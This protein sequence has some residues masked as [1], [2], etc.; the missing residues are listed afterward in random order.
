MT[1]AARADH[2]V[3]CR[4]ARR[5]VQHA[6]QRVAADQV[7]LRDAPRQ[8]RI[9]IARTLGLVVGRDGDGA[10]IDDSLMLRV[11]QHIIAGQ[12]VVAVGQGVTHVGVTVAGVGA[13]ERCRGSHTQRFAFDQVG[14]RSR[15]CL[16]GRAAV[17]D[18]ASNRG[19]LDTEHATRNGGARIGGV[20]HIV[21]GVAASQA[22]GDRLAL[23][24]VLVGEAARD[25]QR[26]ARDDAGNGIRAGNRCHGVAVVDLVQRAER[27]V[28]LARRDRCRGR[29]VGADRVVAGVS[30]RQRTADIHQL[31]DGSIL[32]R[33][34]ARR[35]QRNG[36]ALDHAVERARRIGGSGAVIGLAGGRDG[37]RQGLGRDVGQRRGVG[38]QLVVA[39]VGAGQDT[40]HRH[41][42]AIAHV[43]VAEQARGIDG[44][45]VALHHAVQRAGGG[46]IARAV[47]HLAGGRQRTAGL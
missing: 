45:V 47:V 36:V 12:A 10:A 1:S 33:E 7:A 28:Q 24:R 30:A 39:R 27:A 19:A 17:V 44:D 34:G 3:A 38:A 29:A 32:V 15:G 9:H 46:G 11:G 20:Q 31:A 23:A 43:L 37:A 26:I 25:P 14:Q 42:L 4:L 6:S 21:A 35:R 18:L 13:V 2:V 8:R 22:E 16:G 40:V 5:A 41:Q